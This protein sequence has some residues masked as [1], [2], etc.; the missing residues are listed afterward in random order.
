MAWQDAAAGS[1]FAATFLL[2]A[3]GRVGK[4]PL[5]RGAVALAGGLVTAVLLRVSWSVV[6]LQV[7]LLIVGLMGLAALAEAA[8][9]LAGLR[10]RLDRL[11]PRFAL[12]ACLAFTAL[13]SAA[14]LNDAAIVVLVPFLLPELRRLGL[15]P[16]RSVVLLAVAANLGSLLTPFG[17]PQNA[18]LARAAGLTVAD[19]LAAQAVPVAAGLA[20]LGLACRLTPT[21]APTG[22]AVPPAAARGRPWLL[23]C[24]ALFLALA[25]LRLPKVGLG[26]AAVLAALLAWAGLRLPLGRGADRALGRSVDPNV[27]ALFVGLYLLTGGLPAWAPIPDLGALPGLWGSTATVAVLSNAIGNVPAV[28]TLLQLDAAW[29]VAHA[30]FLVTVSTMGGAVLLTGS[31]ASLLAADQARRHGTEVTFGAF[32]RH[33]APWTLPVLLLGAWLTWPSAPA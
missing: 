15:P 31:A 13:A 17:N 3:L 24:L 12:W 5:P 18:V 23:A 4:V 26:T 1:V 22:E 30:M 7:I 32:L 21:S 20:L 2:L 16:V 25:A 33:A 19:F 11:P 14:I 6:D 29:T 9:V 27:V 28:L 8:G 10:R